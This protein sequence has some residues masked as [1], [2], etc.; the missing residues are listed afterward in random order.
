MADSEGTLIIRM[1]PGITLALD[2]E[3][4]EDLLENVRTGDRYLPDIE[5]AIVSA[6]ADAKESA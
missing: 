1:V 5:A 2:L 6:I 4:A 3:E